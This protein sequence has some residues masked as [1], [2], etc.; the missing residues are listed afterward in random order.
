V[1]RVVD[2]RAKKFQQELKYVLISCIF[3]FCPYGISG[4]FV[5]IFAST[6]CYMPQKIE[7]VKAKLALL[8][9]TIIY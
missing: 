2:F 8:Q 7:E 3:I 6:L 5:I 9:Q 1:S 4:F